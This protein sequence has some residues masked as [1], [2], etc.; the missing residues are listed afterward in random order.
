M[1]ERCIRRVRECVSISFIEI[2]DVVAVDEF[3][4]EV[5]H[6]FLIFG[7]SHNLEA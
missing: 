4:V 3:D 1:R 5:G 7:Y 6:I 2:K